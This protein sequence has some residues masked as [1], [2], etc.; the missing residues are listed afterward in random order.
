MSRFVRDLR[1][2]VRGLVRA[3]GF[4]AVAILT[5][6][7]GIGANVAIF[8]VVRGVLLKPLPFR[9]ADRVVQI[10][11]DTP[12]G[13]DT[14]HSAGDFLDLQRMSQS[15]EA[16]AGYREDLVAVSAK[17][18]EPAQ[19]TGVY[20]TSAFFDVLGV[21]AQAGRT[22][23][24][25]KTA[26][27]LF[28]ISFE[29]WRTEFGADPAA[30]GRSFRLNGQAWQ[31]VGVMPPLVRW[32][33]SAALW[34][35]SP[36]AVPPSPI[37]H[38][39]DPT[40]RDVQYFSAIARLRPSVTL[41]AAQAEATGISETLRHNYSEANRGRMLRLVPVRDELIG[42]VR[43]GLLVLQAVVGVV[44]LIACANISG[45][46]VARASGRRREL[47]IRAAL[48]ARRRDLTMHLLT[49]SVVLGLVGGF[50]GLLAGGWLVRL[51]P[52]VMPEGLP[53][54]DAI[55]LDWIVVVVSIAVALVT[56]VLFGL[57]PAWQASRA[58]A[59]VAMKDAGDRGSSAR[60]FGRSALVVGELALTLVLLAS[61]G[62]LANSFV[63]L[64][65]VDSGFKPEHVLVAALVL[66]QTRYPDGPRQTA[67]YD[68]LLDS[69]SQRPELEVAGVGF[70]GPLKANNASGTLVIEGW[71][72][73]RK[74]R[75]F[76]H[77]SCVSG[78]FFAAMGI[79]L[80][81]GR[82]FT[83][84]DRGGAPDVVILN[85]AVARRYWPGEPVVGKR[86]KFDN[87]PK[88]P[89][90][91]VVGLVADTR[92]AGLGEDPPPVVYVPYQQFPLPFTNLVVRSRAPEATVTALLRTTLSTIDRDLP[93][94]EF[95]TLQDV[96]DRSMDEPRFQTMFVG[97][98]A[99]VALALAAV[100]L[101]GLVSFTVQQ[102][103]REFGIRVALGARPAQVLWPVL[104]QGAVLAA[105]G[106]GAGLAGA[107]AATRL[108][109]AFLFGVGATD[110]ATFAAVAALLLGV[111]LL[112]A[113]IPSRRAA[114]IDPLEAL[115]E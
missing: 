66:P 7:L 99:L 92:Q 33:E 38:G 104:R 29:T 86:L 2:A 41:A 58:S 105:V 36:K 3:P 37:D 102:R 79:P 106:I 108:L 23:A 74:E 61:A 76:S 75:P 63:R 22:F 89:W 21:P 98:F 35:L 31:L 94:A 59:A 30:V 64:Q 115:R 88:T 42:D 9:D 114:R 16:V 44:L 48:G 43:F 81:E 18:G 100:G 101:Y 90:A 80:T 69:T 26:E 27:R 47:A 20:V 6:A 55:G 5:L 54:T 73:S 56:S 4:A 39:D 84:R 110:P 40:T 68:R 13:H 65:R 32:P 67:L 72:L 46:L 50:I 70:P 111:A 14:S 12:D 95:S 25:A 53:R 10:A 77:I 51:L 34:M 49:E 71:P 109:G 78:G 11:V 83:E 82:T 96:L 91:T 112:A 8:S 28:V 85:A 17:P 19:M 62:L 24:G 57:L 15:F 93:F 107:L 103:T 45:L 113:Y 97:L 1:Q 87:N 60:R 52:H